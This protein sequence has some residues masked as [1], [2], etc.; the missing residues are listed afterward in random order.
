MGEDTG[1]ANAAGESSRSPVNLTFS[2]KKRKLSSL[3]D[4]FLSTKRTVDVPPPGWEP[5]LPSD[6]FLKEFHS[7]PSFQAEAKSSGSGT[8][9]K[10]SAHV[11]QMGDATDDEDEDLPHPQPG[12]S[13]SSLTAAA[14]AK[15]KDMKDN[16]LVI[17]LKIFNLPYNLNEAELKDWA[18][19]LHVLLVKIELEVKNDAFIGAA[20][21]WAMMSNHTDYNSDDSDEEIEEGE[22]ET[23][24]Q[25]RRI[26]THRKHL[27]R[28]LQDKPCKG[29][30]VRLKEEG[31]LNMDG[32]GG[33]RPSLG[34]GSR[35][36]E[37]LVNIHV[38]CNR[39]GEVGHMER[40][41]DGTERSMPCHLCAGGDHEASQ[42]PNL[43]C[44]RCRG[45]GHNRNACTV[46]NSEISQAARRRF[47][48]GHLTG[49]LDSLAAR[50]VVC[51]QCGS[52][53]HN[54]RFC[55]EILLPKIYG[56]NDNKTTNAAPSRGNGGDNIGSSTKKT[57]GSKTIALSSHSSKIPVR[58]SP[59]DVHSDVKC[60]VCHKRG[61]A[62]CGEW[63]GV[64]Y[65]AHVSL[66]NQ[67]KEKKRKF[68]QTQPP[69]PGDGGD[70]VVQ[71]IRERGSAVKIYCPHCGKKGHHCDYVGSGGERDYTCC[72]EL[73]R[74]V[75]RLRTQLVRENGR[76]V[77]HFAGPPPPAPPSHSGYRGGGGSGGYSS[78]SGGSYSRQVQVVQEPRFAAGRGGRGVGGGNDGG[79]MNQPFQRGNGG[80]RGGH[81][82]GGW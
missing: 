16:P 12:T 52:T 35:Y 19:K 36:Y 78:G 59:L 7:D 72:N 39:C 69:K 70:E 33:K 41:C 79:Y 76:S 62:I 53:R 68:G 82:R 37:R 38:K 18:K 58:T 75:N 65:P 42:C 3:L 61:H 31:L 54:F 80:G 73:Q 40:E 17:Q 32:G 30:P 60:L 26:A 66:A 28:C 23:L 55:P 24:A 25:T 64:E 50:G 15:V 5:V 57:G 71:M 2:A 46:T 34:G 11:R 63:P 43:V 81:G 22:T 47:D 29:R 1:K 56:T 4:K 10:G 48:G 21:V 13:S 74:Q 8:K 77:E 27:L 20:R 6:E 45:F 44:F 51:S 14:A 67:E 9:D 49:M